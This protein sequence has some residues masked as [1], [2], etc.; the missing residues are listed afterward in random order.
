MDYVQ[1]IEEGSYAYVNVYFRHP[2]Y[3]DKIETL[4]QAVRE[5]QKEIVRLKKEN[6]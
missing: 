3:V 6:T 1:V 5:I 4:Q 2:K